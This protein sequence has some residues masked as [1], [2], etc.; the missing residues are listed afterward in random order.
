MLW[1]WLAHH[2]LVKTLGTN[3]HLAR[4]VC[5]MLPQTFD[6][7]EGFFSPYFFMGSQVANGSGARGGSWAL[8]LGGY[9]GHRYSRSWHVAVTSLT[10]ISSLVFLLGFQG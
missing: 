1:W 4:E 3:F 8:V 2:L 5:K 6:K 10:L 7:V 9:L